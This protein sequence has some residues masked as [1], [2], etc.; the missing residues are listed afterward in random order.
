MSAYYLY[1]PLWSKTGIRER[2]KKTFSAWNRSYKGVYE[3]SRR[4]FPELEPN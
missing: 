2:V 4:K 1:T 3:D